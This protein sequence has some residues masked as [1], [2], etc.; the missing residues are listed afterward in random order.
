M[1][2]ITLKID[3]DLLDS[4]RRIARRQNSSLIAVMRKMLQDLVSADTEAH[5]AISGLNDFYQRC[6][7]RVG[8]KS[9]TRDELHER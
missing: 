8:N 6:T 7:A 2:N 4:A 1:A 9:W 5:E 3:D